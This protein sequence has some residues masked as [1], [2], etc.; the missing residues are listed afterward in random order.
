VAQ[1]AIAIEQ[2]GQPFEAIAHLVRKARG[3]AKA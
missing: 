1:E 3:A 2:S